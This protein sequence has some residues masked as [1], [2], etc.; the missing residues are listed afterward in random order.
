[1]IVYTAIYTLSV[2]FS[3]DYSV[4]DVK[5]LEPPAGQE[6]QLEKSETGDTTG[7][8]ISMSAKATFRHFSALA[9]GGIFLELFSTVSRWPELARAGRVC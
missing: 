1:M 2:N 7:F 9:R 6:V 8:Y 4:N 5:T 3:V